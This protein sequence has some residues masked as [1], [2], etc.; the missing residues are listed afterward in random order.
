MPIYTQEVGP[1][2]PITDYFNK[3]PAKSLFCNLAEQSN[4][5]LGPPAISS[6]HLCETI[7]SQ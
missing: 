6:K 7:Y 5:E 1:A 3:Q 4:P 2:V